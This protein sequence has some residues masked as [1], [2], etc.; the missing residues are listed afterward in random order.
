[1]I[2]SGQVWVS[3]CMS[4]YKRPGLLK[5][6][7]RS[8]LDQTFPAFHIIVSDN[9]PEGSAEAVVQELRDSRIRYYNN[10]VNLGMIKSFNKSIER[11]ETEYIVMITDDDPVYHNMLETLHDL[12]KKYP[13]YGVYH[14]GCDI[15]VNT[16]ALAKTMKRNVGTNSCLSNDME[17]GESKAY[18][19][20]E[21]PVLFFDRKIS[22]YM[23]WSVGVVKKEIL[24]KI[25][26][27][28]N[29]G[30]P[31]LGDICYTLLTCS[32]AGV[33]TINT[34]L[35][36]QVLHGTNYG[37]TM[38]DNYAVF[39]TAAGGFYNWVET[40]LSRREDWGIIKRKMET[41]MARSFVGYAISTKKHLRTTKQSLTSF[42][43]T[44]SKI[45]KIRYIRKWRFKYY[46][47][48]YFPNL[49]DLAIEM[50]KRYFKKH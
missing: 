17:I 34:S 31:F 38:N 24:L 25:G 8:I 12:Y 45:F 2:E 20:S 11:A 29:Y 43:K 10:G 1:M 13:G 30:S 23:L 26:G 21:F 46:L 44:F 41:F 5:K 32:L 18:S 14:G 39:Y 22:N 33:A 40:R 49:F 4:T 9:D 19:S 27:I 15:I 37:Y 50:K 48:T 42:N 28:P 6:T 36:C 16:P 7:L 47:A 35:G 3:F